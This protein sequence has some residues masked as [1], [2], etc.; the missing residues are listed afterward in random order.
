MPFDFVHASVDGLMHFLMRDFQDFFDHSSVATAKKLDS[1][2][3]ITMY[4][5]SWHSFWYDDPRNVAMQRS[6]A[7]RIANLNAIS[8]QS[9]P[10]LFV[11]EVASTDE[12]RKASKLLRILHM[13]FGPCATLLLIVD[14]QGPDPAGPVV[15]DSEPALMVYFCESSNGI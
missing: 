15:V 6:Y 11:R 12:L 8:A 10:V 13:K 2:E 7:T 9:Q 14:N 5:S 3:R 1:E 4:R